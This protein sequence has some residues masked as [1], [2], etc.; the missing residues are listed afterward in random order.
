MVLEDLEIGK[1]YIII[2]PDNTEEEFK[3]LG[4]NDELVG[5]HNVELEDGS[6][7]FLIERDI[8][9]QIVAS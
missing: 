7:S 2:Y 6:K 5:E 3:Y 9:K 1:K 4:T 8:I